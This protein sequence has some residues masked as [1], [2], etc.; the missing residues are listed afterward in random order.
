MSCKHSWAANTGQTIKIA[1]NMSGSLRF[2]D[3]LPL[4]IGRLGGFV[5]RITP[6]TYKKLRGGV[7][8]GKKGVDKSAG[9]VTIGLV[10]SGK[11]IYPHPRWHPRCIPKGFAARLPPKSSWG[12]F[13]CPGSCWGSRQV[14]GWPSTGS[15]L[16][17][18][19][20]PKT[21][22]IMSGLHSKWQGGGV[23]LA[24]PRTTYIFFNFSLIPA[25]SQ[26]SPPRTC[27]HP[28]NYPLKHHTPAHT[29]ALMD[30]SC[31]IIPASVPSVLDIHISPH[32]PAPHKTKG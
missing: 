20:N 29:P 9:D 24:H 12:G 2:V 7:F 11:Y 21:T 22:K 30:L 27:T 26:I 13:L 19:E 25:Y 31:R 1:A 32:I 5:N 4:I 6:R 10:L 18:I 8:F 14:R 15:R 3:V 17:H 16:G 28:Y 23:T